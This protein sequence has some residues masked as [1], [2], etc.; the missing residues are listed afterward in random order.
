[1]VVE[2]RISDR[3]VRGGDCSSITGLGIPY[4]EHNHLVTRVR[5]SFEPEMAFHDR[6]VDRARRIATFG[7]K[8]AI[9]ELV[10]G[11]VAQR[12]QQVQRF[13]DGRGTVSG[14]HDTH[15]KRVESCMR[16]ASRFEALHPLV[17]ESKRTGPDGAISC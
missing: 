15:R 8:D 6:E 2:L 12:P 7:T 16:F 14:L 10:V 1:M 11:C 5:W 17:V 4:R 9:D 13:G 3:A